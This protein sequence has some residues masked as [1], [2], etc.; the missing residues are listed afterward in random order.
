[1]SEKKQAIQ[2]LIIS[3]CGVFIALF[4]LYLFNQNLLM[5]FS[6]GA[7]MIL[8]ILTQ[9]LLFLVPEI[10]MIKHKERLSSLGFRKENIPQQ[11]LIGILIA[12]LLSLVLTMLPIWLGFKEMVG[13]T[14]YTEAWKFLY[15]FIYS[16]FGVALVEEIIF[17]GYIYYKLLEIK[18]SRWYAIIISSI[19]FGFFHIFNFDLIQIIMTTV[20]GL[21]F[22]L[23][24][25]KINGCTTLSLII[26][27]GIYDGLIILCVAYL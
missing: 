21:M 27:H 25:E 18:N 13:S 24:R 6:I 10:L 20:I 2:Q 4:G 15:Q 1:M 5:K 17:R 9:W 23:F 19:I 12:L 16:I 26:A 14:N 3:I 8:M 7:R 11:I 22:C